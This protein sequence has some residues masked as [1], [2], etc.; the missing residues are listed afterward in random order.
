MRLKPRVGFFFDRARIENLARLLFPL[1]R[2]EVCRQ[3][4]QLSSFS[5]EKRLAR[6][7]KIEARNGVFSQSIIMGL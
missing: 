5:F 3:D 7:L 6:V 1:F 4:K 2:V